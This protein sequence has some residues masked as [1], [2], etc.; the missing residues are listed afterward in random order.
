MNV[1]FDGNLGWLVF[2]YRAHA[3][4]PYPIMCMASYILSV[5]TEYPDSVRKS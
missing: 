2:F 4:R 3:I 5:K 1:V